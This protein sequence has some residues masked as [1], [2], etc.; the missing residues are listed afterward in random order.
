MGKTPNK[1]VNPDE[2]VAIGAAIQGG[3]LAG[4]SSVK[5]LLLLDVTPLSLGIET[6]GG[7]MT[8]LI[9]KNTTIPAQKSQVFST[10]EDNQTAV[11]VAVYQGERSMARDNKHLGQFE[12]SGIA[13]AK[14][15]IPQIEITFAINANGILEVSAKD[16][17]TG[18]EHKITI[19][20]SSGL[21]KEEIEKMKAD[22]EK[23]AEEDSKKRRL[24]EVKNQ[25]EQA[26]YSGERNLQD[27]KEKIS[28]ELKT[29]LTEG[30]RQAKE[31]LGNE[32][33]NIEQIEEENQKLQ[34]IISKI[35]EEI[36]KQSPQQEQSAA[37]EEEQKSE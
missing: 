22:A 35:G 20:N 21:T 29:E 5:D 19:T 31:I 11:T 34:N 18:K 17:Q 28:E 27:F 32:S 12:L 33:S 15:G 4:D 30:I 25:L 24:I 13:P 8:T 6:L 23:Y 37:T 7:V 9:P 10:A 14:R 1:S 36:N 3:I 2:A 26:I 16:K